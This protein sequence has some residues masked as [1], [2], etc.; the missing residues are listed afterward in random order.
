MKKY[1]LLS[2]TALITSTLLSGCH[3]NPTCCE[4]IYVVTDDDLINEKSKFYHNVKLEQVTG[5]AETLCHDSSMLL[6]RDLRCALVESLKKANYLTPG[7]TATYIL[8]VEQVSIDVLSEG[9]VQEANVVLR[10]IFRNMVTNTV[11]FNEKFT[12]RFI[13]TY[14]D[15]FIAPFRIVFAVGQATKG[16]IQKIIAK[17]SVE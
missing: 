9:T 12:T 15:A 1:L 11:I 3:L 13:A 14:K 10:G 17:I 8:D 16:C 5:G 7:T 4:M 6:D 2:T